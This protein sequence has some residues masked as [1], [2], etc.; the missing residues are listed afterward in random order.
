MFYLKIVFFADSSHHS[1]TSSQFHELINYSQ[2]SQFLFLGCVSL[3]PYIPI[4]SFLTPSCT[5]FTTKLSDVLVSAC[6]WMHVCVN[7]PD[8]VT[9]P[10]LP[11]QSRPDKQLKYACI[12][13]FILSQHWSSA[14]VPRRKYTVRMTNRMLLQ[15]FHI[16]QI[17]FSA[18]HVRMMK[19][20]YKWWCVFFQQCCFLIILTFACFLSRMRV[21]AESG[22]MQLFTYSLLEAWVFSLSINTRWTRFVEIKGNTDAQVYIS[23]RLHI[24]WEY[25]LQRNM[26][27]LMSSS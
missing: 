2:V 20:L 22:T 23:L 12:A 19:L 16:I 9:L 8:K 24:H 15:N 17:I 7:E 27:P 21:S 5:A 10:T 1:L 26:R 13:V 6:V 4:C 3:Q 18:F 11:L 14:E 25:T